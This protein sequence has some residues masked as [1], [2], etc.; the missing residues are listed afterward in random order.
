LVGIDELVAAGRNRVGGH[1]QGF[2]AF[3]RPLPA[4]AEGFDHAGLQQGEGA[5]GLSEPEEA[6]FRRADIAVGALDVE[7]ADAR[8]G[9]GRGEA[10]AGCRRYRSLAVLADAGIGIAG[11]D[12][13][14]HTVIDAVHRLRVEAGIDPQIADGRH[15][16]QLI[17]RGAAMDRVEAGTFIAEFELQIAVNVDDQGAGRHRLDRLRLGA[18]GQCECCAQSG[19]RSQK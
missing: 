7:R 19:R 18:A 4:V 9:V 1:H 15:R 16:I 10:G 17:G 14:E 6:G 3:E 13:R 5:V 8:E 2:A 12:F 11:T